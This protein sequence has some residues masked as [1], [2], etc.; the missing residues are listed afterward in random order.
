MGEGGLM[1]LQPPILFHPLLDG[2]LNKALAISLLKSVKRDGIGNLI[3][4]L[5]NSDYFTAPASTRFHDAFQGGLCLHSLKLMQMFYN[6][7]EEWEKPLPVDSVIVCGLLHD[8]CKIG[9]YKKTA[10][11]YEKVSGPKGHGTLSV[12]RIEEHIK[13]TP[14]ETDIIFFHMGLFGIFE[15]R[16][17]DTLVP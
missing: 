1:A 8:L 16:E 17:H 6:E 12:S 13:L 9:A 5:C 2:E 10:K 4:Y 11:G 3:K 15:Y 7:N 14:Q